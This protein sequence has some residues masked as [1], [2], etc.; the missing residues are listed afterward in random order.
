[1]E[2][3]RYGEADARYQEAQQ[4]AQQAGDR[5]LEGALLQHRGSLQRQQGN[6][7]QAVSLYQQAMRLFQ[8]AGDQGSEMSTS[9]LLGTAEAQ[10]GNLDAAQAWFERASELAQKLND[11]KHQGVVAQNLGILYQTRAEQSNDPAQR[12]A[13]LRQ[14]VQSVQESLSIHSERQDQ[15]KAAS[16]YYQLGVLYRMLGDLAQAEQHLQQAQAIYE[17]LD[18]YELY[19]VYNELALVAHAHVDAAA[20]AAWKIKREAKEAELVWL[21]GVGGQMPPLVRFEPLLRAIAAVARGDETQRA[22]IEAL[23]PQLEQNGWLIADATRRIWAGERDLAALTQGLDI[24]DTALVARILQFVADPD[25]PPLLP[26][27]DAAPAAGLEQALAALPASIRSAIQQ[28]DTV[29]LQRAFDAL[30]PQEQQQVAAL[31]QMEQQQVA[32]VLRLAVMQNSPFPQDDQTVQV[33]QQAEPLLQAIAAIARGDTA[34]KI[35]VEEALAAMEQQGFHLRAAAQRIWAGERDAAALTAGLDNIV[36]AL[37]QRVLT[38]LAE[39][40]RANT[41]DMLE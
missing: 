26:E 18:H 5:G 38:L 32:E 33:L 40:F 9:G 29:A 19:K 16:S 41:L 21:R 39:T 1:M 14:A 24:Q 34:Q 17:S 25:A 12:D 30:P 2:M 23:L 31:L 13:L 3:Q 6:Y 27:E 28:Q 22:E 4:A 20:A 36:S 35:E 37:V 7:D 10:R 15:V 8:Q 11:R